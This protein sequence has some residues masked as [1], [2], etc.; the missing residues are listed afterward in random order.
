M[1]DLQLAAARERRSARGGERS[2]A[3]LIGLVV[4]M[5][6]AAVA[7]WLLMTMLEEMR[8]SRAEESEPVAGAVE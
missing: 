3:G 6:G 5:A 2:H 1:L 7:L 8:P 4:I